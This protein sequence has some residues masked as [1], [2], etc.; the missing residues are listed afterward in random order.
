MIDISR[1][2]EE[3]KNKIN[4]TKKSNR[5]VDNSHTFRPISNTNLRYD[6]LNSKYNTPIQNR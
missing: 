6:I 1:R 4:F 2:Y 5:S 3:L